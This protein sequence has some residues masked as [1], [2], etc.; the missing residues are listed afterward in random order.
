MIC[1]ALDDW[2]LLRFF[3]SF[4]A[5]R[6]KARFCGEGNIKRGVRRTLGNIRM[7]HTPGGAGVP[8]AGQG[9]RGAAVSDH[10]VV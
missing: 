8:G 5:R 6:R 1:H 10:A 2:W 7:E 3:P 4:R 9:P